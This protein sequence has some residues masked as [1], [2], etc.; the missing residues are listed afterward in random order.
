M[1]EHAR[2]AKFFAPLSAGEPGSF[3]LIDDAAQ[4][5]PPEGKSLIITTDSVIAGIHLPH[6]ASTSELAVKLMRRNLSDL[7]AM[8]AVPWRYLLNIHTPR[9]TEDDWFAALANALQREQECYALSLIGGDTTAGDGPV[10]LTLTLLGLGNDT[11]LLRSGARA[12]DVVYVSGT[13]GDAAL[14]LRLI[15]NQL[16]VSAED[17]MFLHGRYYAPEPRLALGAAL[18]G[19]ASAAIDVSDGL[20]SDASKLARAS[21]IGMTLHASS[22]PLSPAARRALGAHTELWEHI[23]NGGDDYE[24]LF[25]APVSAATAIEKIVANIGLELTPIGT[26]TAAQDVRVLDESGRQLTLNSSGFSH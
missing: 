4:I 7:A 15:Q 8:G 16:K 23:L 20:V 2:I 11:P 12:G 25:T 26:V 21:N 24:L 18:C 5:T 14:G 10:H 3:Y 19:V 6:D 13:I 9:T 22:I 17:E 1:R